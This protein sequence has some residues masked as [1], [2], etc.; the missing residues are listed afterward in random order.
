LTPCW[1]GIG[2]RCRFPGASTTPPLL[3]LAVVRVG[4]A[5]AEARDPDPLRLSH[6]SVL[7]CTVPT[8]RPTCSATPTTRCSIAPVVALDDGRDFA[9]FDDELF[10]LLLRFAIRALLAHRVPSAAM[11]QALLRSRGC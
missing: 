6:P 7:A 2:R 9:F 3:A 5:V 10:G 8:M 11:A 1:L 4:S